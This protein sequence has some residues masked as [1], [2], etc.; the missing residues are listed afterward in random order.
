M[1]LFKNS[2]TWIGLDALFP[3]ISNVTIE[4]E[5]NPNSK[6]LFKNKKTLFF[7]KFLKNIVFL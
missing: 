4:F 6:T 5:D 3:V 7:E 2:L 1:L